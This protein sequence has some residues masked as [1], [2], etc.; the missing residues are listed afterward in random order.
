[1]AQHMGVF[2]ENF[3]LM[4]FKGIM[5]FDSWTD[6]MV[7]VSKVN[8]GQSDA[9]I[10]FVNKV[11]DAAFKAPDTGNPPK[12]PEEKRDNIN[13]EV[14]KQGLTGTEAGNQTVQIDTA[15]ISQAITTALSQG[16]RNVTVTNMTVQKEY[17]N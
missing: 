13:K 9:V 15:G 8:I 4:D 3:N 16:L 1:M 17:K 10:D 11:V 6:S 7:K 12:T 5:A 2:A 14:E